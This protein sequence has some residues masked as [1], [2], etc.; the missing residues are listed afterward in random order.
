MVSELSYKQLSGEIRSLF[1]RI[2]ARL[3]ELERKKANG[4][5]KESRLNRVSEVVN[6]DVSQ[7]S[8]SWR[9]SGVYKGSSMAQEVA[10]GCTEFEKSG[11]SCLSVLDSPREEARLANTGASESLFRVEFE[12]ISGRG[13]S[14]SPREEVS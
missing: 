9:V 4:R 14:A 3:E 10:E 2:I 8:E 7:K 6:V 1:R 5:R 13:T 12:V 11:T